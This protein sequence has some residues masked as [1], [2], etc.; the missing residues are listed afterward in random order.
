MV[1][2]K[3]KGAQHHSSSGKCKSKLQG[4]IT[5]HPLG[6]LLSKRQEVTNTSEHVEEREPCYTVGGNV[7]Q[8]S[9]YGQQYGSS[10]KN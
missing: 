1:T 4:D 9:H 7:Y 8:H 3:L 5:S 10:L 2:G 6:C